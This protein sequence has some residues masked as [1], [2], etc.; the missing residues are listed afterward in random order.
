MVTKA[1]APE[2]LDEELDTEIVDDQDLDEGQDQ[3]DQDE[4]T[5]GADQDADAEDE[6][7]ISVIFGDE[8]AP[9]SSE[10]Q[11]TG[12]VRKLREEIRKRDAELTTLRKVSVPQTIEVG[13]KPTL[14][15]CDYDEQ[16][17]ETELDSWKE[18]K[19]KADEA[20][21]AAQRDAEA[22]KA[23]WAETVADFE[24][25]KTALKAPDF[26]V[27]E[28]EVTQALSPMQQAI[29]IN[30]ADDSAKV[31]YALGKH[32]QK[33]AGLAAIKDPIKFAVAVSKLEGTL[34]VTRTTRKAPEP[35]RPVRGSAQL[36]A[37]S[38]KHLER[39]EKEAD[40]TGDRTKIVQY[41]R[42]LKS[43]GKK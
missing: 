43:Q 6:E 28:E 19:A 39:L 34:K 4:D 3:G 41:K 12:L 30:A 9:A 35:D 22:N 23:A 37:A 11:S 15:T 18:R 25:K 40:R 36:S 29:V 20:N 42:Q 24:R 14:E 5:G 17:F 13:D 27:A 1:D 31:I 21:V 33:L 7:E 8:A 10:E 2:G 26:E 32:P 16:R 38:D